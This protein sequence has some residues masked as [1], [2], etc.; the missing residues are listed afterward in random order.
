MCTYTYQI[1]IY[2]YIH[3]YIHTYTYIY[4]YIYICIGETPTAEER[5][6]GRVVV[7]GC[8]DVWGQEQEEGER[9]DDFV[10]IVQGHRGA[11][12]V[13]L[14]EAGGLSR[15]GAGNGGGLGGEQEAVEEDQEAVGERKREEQQEQQERAL[16]ERG[17]G[18]EEEKEDETNPFWRVERRRL[19]RGA[20]LDLLALLGCISTKVQIL[21]Q[22]TGRCSSIS[23]RLLL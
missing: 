22:K 15:S 6:A 21:T 16:E 3:T 1:Y 9:E 7:R 4:I 10:D 2:I 19:V 11:E 5:A 8:G 14:Q 13:H 23:L 20:P 18:R 17:E 12:F